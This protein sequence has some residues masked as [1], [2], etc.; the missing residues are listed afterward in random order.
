VTYDDG[1]KYHIQ[2]ETGARALCKRQPV[3]QIQY[4]EQPIQKRS[5]L[6]RFQPPD[7]DD[8]RRYAGVQETI[9]QHHQANCF[10]AVHVLGTFQGTNLMLRPFTEFLIDFYEA[11]EFVRELLEMYTDFL[12][13]DVCRRLEM[14]A[15]G[16]YVCDDL[17]MSDRLFIHPEQYR[18]IIKPLH[19]KQIQRFKKYPNVKVMLHC[20]G[21]VRDIMADLIEVGF[22]EINPVDRGDHMFIEKLKPIYGR[23]ITFSGGFDRHVG[24]MP[25]EELLAHINEVIKVGK[26]GGRYIATFP[27]YPEM[28]SKLMVGAVRTLMDKSAYQ[29]GSNS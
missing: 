1:N 19:R 12:I 17:G 18:Q 14:G 23:E 13:A 28:D 7:L 6:S 11:P 16:V 29:Q 26:P 5:D 25:E 3:T 8:P 10:V 2:C 15:D 24:Q 21:C 4:V 20:D 9:E 22:D 27:V